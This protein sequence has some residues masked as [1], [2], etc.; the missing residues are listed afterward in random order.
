MFATIDKINMKIATSESPLFYYFTEYLCMGQ[1]S[2][3]TYG[4]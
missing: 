4:R 2:T 1:K 3:V